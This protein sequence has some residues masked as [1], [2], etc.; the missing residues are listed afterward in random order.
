MCATASWQQK[1]PNGFR[2]SPKNVPWYEFKKQRPLVIGGCWKLYSK[3]VFKTEGPQRL[4][5]LVC[6]HLVHLLLL[7]LT[8]LL[9]LLPR[10]VTTND[11]IAKKLACRLSLME[12]ARIA[13]PLSTEWVRL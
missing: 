12:A 8:R 13:V 7:R 3:T 11:D 5:Q 4:N 6:H 10:L 2:L 1:H 9:C